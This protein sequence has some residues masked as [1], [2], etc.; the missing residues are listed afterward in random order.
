M[1]S[2]TLMLIASMITEK[3]IKISIDFS[4]AESPLS[5][6]AEDSR[7]SQ[8]GPTLHSADGDYGDVVEARYLAKP[9]YR[10]DDLVDQRIGGLA[11]A[12]AHL[13]DET[14]FAELFALF[15]TRFGDAV[16]IDHQ[17]IPSPQLSLRLFA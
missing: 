8:A 17:G 5:Y 10:V 2:V 4:M 3:P 7:R 13:L 1:I 14:V 9:A 16:R 12:A 15:D 6:L 11:L